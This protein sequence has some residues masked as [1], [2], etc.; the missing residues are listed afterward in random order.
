MIAL[1]PK[2]NEVKPW[3]DSE[4][5]VDSVL[6][7]EF[8]MDASNEPL[9]T[10]YI[11]GRGVADQIFLTEPIWIGACMTKGLPEMQMTALWEFVSSALPAEGLRKRTKS[12]RFGMQCLIDPFYILM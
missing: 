12:R 8:M 3:K 10:D 6:P 1:G 9:H 5:E 11:I 7:M 4:Q 2:E